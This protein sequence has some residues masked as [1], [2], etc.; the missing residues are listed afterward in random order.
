MRI[1][2][3]PIGC[4]RSPAASCWPSAK[5]ASPIRVGPRSPPARRASTRAAARSTS[6]T[7]PARSSTGSRSRSA[8]G[9]HTRFL[10]QSAS[11]AVLN[12]VVGTDASSILGTLSS[13]GRVF[14]VNPHGIVFGAGARIDTAGFIAS[15][16][17][18]TDSD[19]LQGKLKFEGGGMGVLRNEG[20][21]PRERRHHARR[22]R[23]SRMRVS[24]AA[25]TGAFCSR[26]A[27]ASPSRAPMRRA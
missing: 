24:S 26:P 18:I 4:G 7:R 13:N 12:R 27:E 20:R 15:T 5:R 16:L 6:P 19:F 17:N 21:D 22:A 11:S 10:Q 25:T 9:E 14:L 1:R 2:R 23:R 3:R 8:A